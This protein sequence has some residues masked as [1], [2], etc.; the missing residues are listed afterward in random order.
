M[1]NVHFK[2]N[3]MNNEAFCIVEYKKPKLFDL[4]HYHPEVQITFCVNGTGDFFIGGSKGQFEVGDL[5]II[6]KNI[7]HVFKSDE[8]HESSFA[9]T[10]TVFV[11]YDFLENT[12]FRLYSFAELRLFLQHPYICLVSKHSCHLLSD[13]QNLVGSVDMEKA[14]LTLSLL[15]KIKKIDTFEILDWNFL[16]TPNIEDTKLGHVICHVE[17]H[18]NE[19]ITISDIAEIANLSVPAFARF[20]KKSTGTTFI[21]YLNDFRIKKA[22]ELLADQDQAIN[23]VAYKTGFNQISN[24]NRT[25][26]RQMGITPT[27]Y[28]ASLIRKSH[29]S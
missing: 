13:F 3:R 12:L 2:I 20:F 22:C 11:D 29:L 7:P 16:S 14:L 10:I 15:R 5:F 24:F 17:R 4:M 21:S 27:N 28:Q 19:V 26:K 6:G 18:F 1:K 8:S 23:E 25:F 9:H